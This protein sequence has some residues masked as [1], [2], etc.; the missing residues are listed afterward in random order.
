MI[1]RDCV[2]VLV[3]AVGGSGLGQML[4]ELGDSSWT[5]V[6]VSLLF[7]GSKIDFRAAL[8]ASFTG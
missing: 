4:L 5:P 2:V 8:K 6:L 7:L 1:R 3:E